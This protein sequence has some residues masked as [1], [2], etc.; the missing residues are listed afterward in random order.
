MTPKVSQAMNEGLLQPF[1]SEEIE[2]AVF[3][4]QPL[5]AP[6]P[7]GFG[8]CFF[9][10]H[11]NTVEGEVTSTVLSFFNS[12]ML[13]PSINTTLV[14]FIPKVATAESVNDYRPISLCNVL[15]KIITKVLANRFKVVLPQIISPQQSAFVP[16]RLISDNIL[17]AY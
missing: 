13:D 17:A 8:V 10:H 16:G 11:W 9:Q 14:A 4:M 7:D 3:K 5:K 15:Y 6:G 12:G 1:L 2:K